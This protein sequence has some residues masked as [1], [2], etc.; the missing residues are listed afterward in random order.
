MRLPKKELVICPYCTKQAK[1][2]TGDKI[3]PHRNDLHRLAF[4]LCEPCNAY[5][6]THKGTLK[7]LGR[8]ANARLRS[9]KQSVH[10]NF[11]PIWKRR[12]LTRKEAYTWLAKEMDISKKDCHVGMFDEKQCV[13]ALA[14]IRDNPPN[15]YK[16]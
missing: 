12:F 8:L 14:I 5:V 7:P 10:R 1:L 16:K 9:L 2:V 11:D 4:F 15:G 13:L 6:G 3:Y